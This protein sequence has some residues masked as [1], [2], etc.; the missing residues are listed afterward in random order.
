MD[1]SVNLKGVLLVSKI[2][3]KTSIGNFSILCF[4]SVFD[5]PVQTFILTVYFGDSL[6]PNLNILFVLV[7]PIQDSFILSIPEN[8]IK[9]KNRG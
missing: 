9:S 3:R 6:N 5:I 8:I 4:F 2:K 1:I 7:F